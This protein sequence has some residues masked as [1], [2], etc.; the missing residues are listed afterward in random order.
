MV[1]SYRVENQVHEADDLILGSEERTEV[2][3]H[4]RR[5]EPWL[6]AVCQSEHLNLLVGS[7]FSAGLALAAGG[8]PASMAPVSIDTSLD[9]A[10][11][12]DAALGAKKMN[13][14][15]ANIED[16]FR[17]ALALHAGL[18]VLKDPRA[19]ALKSGLDRALS[20]FA[21]S[22]VAME[23]QISM[24][25]I[26]DAGSARKVE[27]LLTEFLLSFASRT[28]SRDRLHIFTTNYDRVIEHGLDLLGARPIDRFVG[29]LT[30]R[31]RA[32]RFEVDI[33][34]APPGGR[35]DARP[36]EGVVRLTKLHGSVDWRE[37][38]G[39]IVR[40]ALPFGGQRTL[41]EAEAQG[42]MIF[43][44]AAKDIETAFYPYAELFRDFS[45]AICRPNAALVTYGYGFGD[46]HV[47]RIIRDMLTIPSTHLV[48]ISYDDAGGRIPAFLEACGRPAQISYL[49]GPQLA[50][51]EPLAADFLP[52]PAIDSI[53]KRETE[54][55]ENRR[56][57]EPAAKAE[58]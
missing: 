36:L 54:L 24:A 29:A 27:R 6:S 40:E 47:N 52:K 4:R 44:N 56:R 5:I 16:Q 14:G 43:P 15:A 17:S 18:Q 20:T 50:A 42:L 22:I 38:G 35:G 21:N 28:A 11:N 2:E 12:G 8:K 49:I 1:N 55:L 34:Y 46:D 3:A 30:P 7:G 23:R 58:P 41:T 51:L 37:M 39:D 25:D 9:A 26:F 32:S 33:H 53:S 19:T 13:R 48:A 45:T 31:F 10:I 57:P